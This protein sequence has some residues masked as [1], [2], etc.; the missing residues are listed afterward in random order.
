MVSGNRERPVEGVELVVVARH[1]VAP[2]RSARRDQGAVRRIP[3]QTTQTNG[4]RRWIVRTVSA[5]GR[6]RERLVL[7]AVITNRCP[8]FTLHECP[9]ARDPDEVANPTADDVVEIACDESGSEGENLI[10]STSRVFTH[11]SIDLSVRRSP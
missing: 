8:R 4:A 7:A 2:S 5:L 3:G 6:R 1:L 9:G 11:A 10:R